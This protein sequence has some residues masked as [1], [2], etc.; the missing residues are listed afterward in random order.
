MFQELIASFMQSPQAAQAT[1]ALGAR[2]YSADQVSAIMDAAGPAAASALEKQASGHAE[3]ALGL[4]NIF[5]G[6]A[7]E[8]AASLR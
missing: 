5:G 1:E 7:G 2:G 4:F 6:H 8:S 3:P